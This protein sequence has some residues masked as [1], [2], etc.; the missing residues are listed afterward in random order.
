V[1]KEKSLCGEIRGERRE[2]SGERIKKKRKDQ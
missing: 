2:V 1:P